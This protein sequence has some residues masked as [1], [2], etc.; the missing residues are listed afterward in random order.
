[1]LCIGLESVGL[2]MTLTLLAEQAI[3]AIGTAMDVPLIN[4]FCL[5]ARI[6]LLVG[7][8]LDMS[9]TLAFLAINVKCVEVCFFILPRFYMH[10]YAN[11]CCHYAV[12]RPG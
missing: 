12:D 5:F 6:A 4:E 9:F 11:S 10:C 2:P 3:L 1:M 8:A 7:Y